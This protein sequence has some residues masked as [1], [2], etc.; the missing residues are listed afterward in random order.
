MLDLLNDC[1]EEGLQH[2]C[3]RLISESIKNDKKE[4]IP[5][6]EVVKIIERCASKVREK[7]PNFTYSLVY[8]GVKNLDFTIEPNLEC[9]FKIAKMFPEI[10]V[11][12]DLVG[13]EDD[14]L[15]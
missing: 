5:D 1:R 7:C 6:E 11:G 8:M 12:Y 15:T 13:N 10:A 2:I 9:A 4:G 3:I 14:F